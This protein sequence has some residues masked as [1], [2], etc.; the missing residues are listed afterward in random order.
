[1]P[2]RTE[3]VHRLNEEAG[4]YE[5]PYLSKSRIMSWVKNPEHFRLKYLEGIREPETFPMKRGTNIHETFEHIYHREVEK[6]QF[7]GIG[8]PELLPDDRELWQDFI[9]PYISNFISWEHARWNEADRE[10]DDFLPVGIEEEQWRDPVLGLP[11]EPEWMGLADVVLPAA[12]VPEVETDDGVVIV[13]FKTG[14]VP[15]KKYRD[16]GIHA[17]LEYY[18]ILFE[19]EYDVAAA[20][21]YYPKAD[22]VVIE[23]PGD[24]YRDTVFGAAE[25]M[26]EACDDY[27][28]DVKFEP[29]P[30]PLCGWGTDDDERSALY[31]VCS[32]CTWNVPSDNQ[33]QFEALV[34]EGYSDTEIADHLGC[35]PGESSYWRYKMDL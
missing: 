25:V 4:E 21:A 28:G 2:G 33:N 27:D 31:G 9:E 23:P 8:D 6:G 13:D 11:E 35:K 3:K 5:L 22:R 29:K 14:S 18:T 34:E 19:E 7:V 17:E 12:G 1:M 30:G 10:P 20:M 16:D 32:Q 26:V 24:E 15:D